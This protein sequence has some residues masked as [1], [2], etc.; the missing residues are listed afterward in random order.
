MS[1][2][3][4]T[5]AAALPCPAWVWSN[6][7]N[8]HVAK[9]RSWFG[10]DYVPFESFA[11]GLIHT[12]KMKVVGV[13]SVTLPVKTSPD[14]IGHKSHGQL[15]LN[16][17]LHIPSSVCNI[18]G[19]P[20]SDDYN[21][22]T[23]PSEASMGT[24]MDLNGKAMAYFKPARQSQR[25]ELR[26]S[27]PPIGP[28]LG[29]SPFDPSAHYFIHALWPE[30]EKA[31]FDAF[32]RAPPSVRAND[33]EKKYN[34]EDH[35]AASFFDEKE[36][37]WIESNWGNSHHFMISYGF[38]FYKDEDCL[39]AKSLVHALMHAD[40]DESDEE[41]AFADHIFDETELDWIRSIYGT[42]TKF[43]LSHGL[44]LH[45]ERDCEEAK[46]LVR[47]SM[48]GDESEEEA[49]FADHVFSRKELDWV[50]SNWGTSTNF[51]INH[52]LKFYKNDDY[53]EAQ[54]IVRTFMREDDDIYEAAM[55]VLRS[56]MAN[57]TVPRRD[58]AEAQDI[59]RT[60]M[61]AKEYL[62][63]TSGCG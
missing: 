47:V 52:G 16:N 50:R 31:R 28:R 58:L 12:S 2:G 63:D 49:D 19:S 39:E 32:R 10:D 62:K 1:L 6:N 60:H 3:R 13:G 46:S 18:I 43:M 55:T 38:K 26:L 4:E 54:A 20:I 59:I 36:L 56:R 15:V 42:S 21:L 35:L 23:K 24:I 14:K 33:V 30:S 41:A 44:K 37:A 34:P 5:D 51:M 22:N 48:H 25:F 8:V 40:D 45:R 7:S 61:T 9:D 27:G 53:E 57:K 11:T 29:P 17:V